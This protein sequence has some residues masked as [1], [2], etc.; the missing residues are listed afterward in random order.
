MHRPDFGKVYFGN[1]LLLEP[2]T[3]PIERFDH[4]ERIFSPLELLAQALDVAID[5]TV[6]DVYLIV[7]GGIHQG[8]AAFNYTR[9]GGERLKDDEFRDRKRDRLVLPGAGV[10]LRIHS[11]LASLQHLGGIG[12]LRHRTV[13][14][15]IAP[16]H[17]LDV[18]HQQ[19]LRERLPDEVVRAH[20]RANNSS[21]SSSFEVRKITGTS[22]IWRNRRNISMPSMRGILISRM[23]RSGGLDLKV[24]SAEAPSV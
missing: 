19:A 3:Y 13:L 11:E 12:F 9:P 20:L 4:V 1:L 2:V 18:L 15:A 5:C 17:D 24:S 8:V 21:I 7:I 10:A 22:E 16:E 6:I 23:A 14:G